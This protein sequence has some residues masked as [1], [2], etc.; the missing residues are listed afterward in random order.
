MRLTASKRVGRLEVKAAPQIQR[1]VRARE[2]KEE[3][4]HQEEI[5]Q[6]HYW[7]YIDHFYPDVAQAARIAFESIGDDEEIDPDKMKP[8]GR[9]A[10]EAFQALGDSIP[11]DELNRYHRI[12]LA[13]IM[14]L[15]PNDPDFDDKVEKK[16]AEGDRIRHERRRSEPE[17][18]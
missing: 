13:K 5:R 3:Q 16:W 12:Y 8:E 6:A 7:R 14:G 10:W 2:E 15:D 18:N 9:I 11:T 1:V 17:R 4:E